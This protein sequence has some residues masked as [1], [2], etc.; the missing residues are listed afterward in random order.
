MQ[1]IE[2]PAYVFMTP[3]KWR[4]YTWFAVVY[5][6]AALLY[7][8]SAGPVYWLGAFASWV[9]LWAFLLYVHVLV[10][11]AFHFIARHAGTKQMP[12]K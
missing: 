10:A 9:F 4:Y 2:K 3:R 11:A 8:A 1:S 12:S 6:V 7:W 5:L